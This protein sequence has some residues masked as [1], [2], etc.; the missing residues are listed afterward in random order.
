MTRRQKLLL[1]IF[2]GAFALA[3]GY[4][5]LPTHGEQAP[6]GNTGYAALSPV[7]KEFYDRFVRADPYQK[8]LDLPQML[9]YDGQDKA[10]TTWRDIAADSGLTLVNFWATWCTGCITEVPSLIALQRHYQGRGL[11][12]VFISLDFPQNADALKK[13]MAIAGM[14]P[15]ATYYAKDAEI[16]E[17]L[18]FIGIPTTLIINKNGQALYR[19]AG[20]TDWGNAES[21]SFFDNIIA[22]N[23]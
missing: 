14:S 17:A 12:V 21:F 9:V 6:V 19:F 11:S 1:F 13:R 5:T 15:L 20:D 16:W 22:E 8:P 7:K 4:L 2:M 10:V 23:P 18:K 3:T